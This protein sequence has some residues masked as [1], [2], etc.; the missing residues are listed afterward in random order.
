MIGSGVSANAVDASGRRPPTWAEFL[1]EAAESLSPKQKSNIRSA[2]KVGNYL[3]AC[4]YLKSA[5]GLNWL[6]Y[7]KEK[8]HDPQ[9]KSAEIHKHI[10]DLDAR[11]VVSLNFDLIYDKYVAA[12]ADGTYF[13]KNYYAEDL[14]QIIGGADRYLIKAHGSIDEPSKLIFTLREYARARVKYSSFYRILDSILLLNTVIMIG[15]GL[16]DPDMQLIFENNKFLFENNSHFMVLPSG[17]SSDERRLFEDSRGISIVEYKR[18]G[19]DHSELTSS[20]A[21]LVRMV[22]AK[23]AEIAISEDW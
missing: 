9:F 14:G 23:R 16:N 19:S 17:L 7:L 11:I 22:E 10:F 5:Y 4:E 13:V 2:V 6:E 1:N 8:F 20:I 21:E 18:K 3:Y 15:C 12:N